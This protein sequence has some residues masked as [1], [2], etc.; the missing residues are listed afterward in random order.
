VFNKFLLEQKNGKEW[1]LAARYVREDRW[2]GQTNWTKQFR[3]GDSVYGENIYVNRI[4][5]L[6]KYEWP[7]KEKIITQVSYNLH[8]QDAAYGR[9]SFIARQSTAFAQTFWDKSLSAQHM[10]LS[11]INYKHLWYDDNTGATFKSDSS[12]NAPDQSSTLG[13]FVQDE[14]SFDSLAK[15]KLLSGIRLDYNTVYKWVPSPRL[16]FKWTPHYRLTMRANVASGF[17][18]VNVFTEDHAALTG[19]RTVVFTEKI[20]PEKS[21]NASLNCV[22]K[23]RLTQGRLLILDATAFY[24]HFF[25]KIYA[26]YDLDPKLVVYRNL[27]GYAYSRGAS[28]NAQLVTTSAFKITSGVTFSDVKNVSR[29]SSGIY[30]SSQQLN[31]TRWSGNVIA[32]YE[33]KSSAFR[34]DLTANWYGPQRLAIQPNDFRKEYSP[35]FT[36]INLQVNKKFKSGVECYIGVKNLLNFL[37]KDPLM[38]PQDPFNKLA[39]DSNSNPNNYHFDTAYNY[40]P[41]QGIRGYLGVRLSL[42]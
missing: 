1:S 16:A 17:R 42:F 27:D 40:A 33:F 28:L 36:L 34:I 11:G 32:G 29:D 2:G 22:Y 38:R 5:L 13:M 9:V 6:S 8:D 41:V 20:K 3:G 15:F 37:P 23:M 18:V 31:T 12:G 14:Y 19:A 10:V 26:N 30:N 35:W 21:Y 25:N 4:E 39:N 7:V 24:Y